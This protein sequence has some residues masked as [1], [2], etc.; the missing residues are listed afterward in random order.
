MPHGA[1]E[2]LHGHHNG[3]TPISRLVRNNWMGLLLQICYM[4]W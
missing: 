2:G 3:K 1:L 4:A